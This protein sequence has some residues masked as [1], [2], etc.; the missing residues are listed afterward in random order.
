MFF[1]EIS[2]RE[3]KYRYGDD[4]MSLFFYNYNTY[5]ARGN[6]FFQMFNQHS[7]ASKYSNYQIHISYLVFED[8]WM[9][10]T[11]KGEVSIGGR[12]LQSIVFLK[13]FNND[14][15]VTHLSSND[16]NGDDP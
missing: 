11:L 9:G 2:S 8:S 4:V 6:K 5:K 7:E 16:W 13:K 10:M 12:R 15:V 3:I 14:Y 1:F